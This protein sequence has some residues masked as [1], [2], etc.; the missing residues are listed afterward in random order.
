MEE[1]QQVVGVAGLKCEDA[2]DVTVSV[3][4][5]S[6]NTLHFWLSK[7][8]REAAKQNEE[9][10]PPRYSLYLLDFASTTQPDTQARW[11]MVAL[12]SQ[13]TV[14]FIRAKSH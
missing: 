6:P 14:Q 1:W 3:E 5:V 7:F 13:A 10:Y 8:V 9:R 2:Q 4:H 11:Y 12:A